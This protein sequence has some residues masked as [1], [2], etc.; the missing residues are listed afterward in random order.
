[1]DLKD[2]S[3]VNVFAVGRALK[4]APDHPYRVGG[5]VTKEKNIY[6]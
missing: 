4:G 5:K 2:K 1:M 6:G 3:R